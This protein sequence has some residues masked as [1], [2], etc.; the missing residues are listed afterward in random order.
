MFERINLLDLIVSI[1][2]F[3]MFVS[4]PF[5]DNVLFWNLK[6]Y[7]WQG[8]EFESDFILFCLTKLDV[9]YIVDE[10]F[11]RNRRMQQ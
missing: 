11:A 10:S 4:K 2:F 7:A 9:R 8:R 6:R 5:G 1:Y 3:N